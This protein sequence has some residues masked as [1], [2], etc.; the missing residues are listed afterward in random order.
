M[1]NSL[2]NEIKV[3]V[4]WRQALEKTAALLLLVVLLVPLMFLSVLLFAS[5]GPE[6]IFRQERVGKNGRRFKIWKFR[7]MVRGAYAAHG[8]LLH[9]RVSEGGSFLLKSINDARVTRS[10]RWLRKYHIDE[11]LQLV[12]VL[13]GE[14]SLVGPRP[15]LPEELEHLPAK[16]FSRFEVLPGMTGLAQVHGGGRLDPADYLEYDEEMVRDMSIRL[17]WR[18]L[19][20]T[21][22][23]VL[24]GRG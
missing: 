4:V 19:L 2:R 20:W 14:M 18:V 8:E 15:M 22:A 23:A 6:V 17:Y 1:S 16:A 24:R 10:G 5:S 3:E 9:K 7:T 11:V 12:N 13:R 21:P